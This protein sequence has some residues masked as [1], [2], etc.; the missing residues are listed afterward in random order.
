VANPR[1]FVPSSDGSIDDDVHDL[2]LDDIF[3]DEKEALAFA[4]ERAMDWVEERC[5]SAT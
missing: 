1:I 2:C 5:I 4:R 3:I